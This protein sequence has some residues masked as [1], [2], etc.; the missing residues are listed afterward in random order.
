MLQHA[1]LTL[2]KI[3]S[4]TQLLVA[5]GVRLS[6]LEKGAGGVSDFSDFVQ[7]N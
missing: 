4:L 5:W 1:A 2:A 7:A 6:K 3:C